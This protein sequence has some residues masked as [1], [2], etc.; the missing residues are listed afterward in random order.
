M[1]GSNPVDRYSAVED[2]D[3]ARWRAS[4][5]EILA[6][7]TGQPLELLSFEEIRRKVKAQTFID[8][9]VQDIPLDAILGSVN[10]YQDFTRG[11]LPRRAIG[12]DRWAKVAIFAS[13]KG[14]PPIEVYR[15]GAI[16]FVKD[17]N[18]RVS[19][20]K[21]L[22]WKNIQAYV[23]EVVTQA[24]L[25]P[26][27]TPDA[28]ILKAEY[29][30]FLELSRLNENCPGAVLELTAP[31]QY[32]RLEEHIAAHL[33]GLDPE[34]KRKLPFPD[35]AADWYENAYLPVARYIEETGVLRDFPGRTVT[36]LYLWLVEHRQALE[37]EFGQ[38]IRAEAAT[39]HLVD[40]FS[41]R[42]GRI[43]SRIGSRIRKIILP[44]RFETG[45][46]PGEWRRGKL[47]P[48]QA[49][50][51]PRRLFSDILVTVS[52]KKDGWSS[53]YQ[54]LKIALREGARLHGLHRIES[55]ELREAPQT[56]AIETE[57]NLWCA[58]AGVQ[59][60]ITSAAGAVSE[61]VWEQARWNDLVVVNLTYPPAPQ[62]FAT[63]GPGFR[64][65]VQCCPRPLLAVPRKVSA[66]T[67]VLLAYDGSPKAREALYIAAYMAGEWKL[68]L[69]VL[70]AFEKDYV[71]GEILTDAWKYLDSHAIEASYVQATGPAIQEILITSEEKECD[72]I[73][74]GGHGHHP[75]LNPMLG[76]TV[77]QV[78]REAHKPVLICR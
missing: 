23:E 50:R 17:G 33:S 11:F 69:V 48:S 38:E 59:A 37:K 57:F 35:V 22:G 41:P 76:N 55:E 36:D 29:T 70:T 54:A 12:R 47:G 21:Q 39:R 46:A 4:L 51:S 45:P 14:L 62:P 53:L 30:G 77:D 27:L 42:P 40:R 63:L 52:G 49:Q 66:L 56:I 71:S 18:H 10:R 64:A 43:V 5:Q 24:P 32:S 1:P 9:G 20:A 34:N 44:K 13:E 67:R 6:R 25:T 60:D 19:A 31:G 78:L 68:P 2:Y 58:E 3:R 75:A 16:Y 73:L 8:R 65:L 26:D 61:R 15:I 7:F 72:L 74:M 28:L